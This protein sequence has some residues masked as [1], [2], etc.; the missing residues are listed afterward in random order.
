[1]SRARFTFWT[2]LTLGGFALVPAPTFG[3]GELPKKP[4]TSVISAHRDQPRGG[5]SKEDLPKAREHFTKFA[6]YYADTIAHPTVWKAS[7]EFKLEAPGTRIPTLDGP[8]GL[9]RDLDRYLIEFVPGVNRTNLEPADYIRELGAALDEALK[10]L[11]ETNPE[12]IVRVNAARMLAHVARTGAP[13]HFATITSLLANPNTRTEVKYYLF[14]A[15]GAVLSASDPYEPKLRKHAMDAKTVGALIKTLEDCINTPSLLYVGLPADI[16]PEDVTADQ[17]AVI[18]LVR[19][20]AIRALAQTKFVSFPGPDGKML[21]PAHTLARVALGDPAFAPAPGPVEA[22]EAAIGLCNM[23]PVA[24]QLKGGFALVKGYN[25]DVAVEAILTALVTFA[26]PRAANAYDRTLAWRTYALRI[27]DAM[28]TWRPL[29]D[30]E[31]DPT[32]PNKFD[33]TLVPQVVD[34][35]FKE[36]IPKV[37]APIDKVDNTGK[38]DIGTKVEIEWLRT[39]LAAMRS[40][41]NRKTELFSGV[42]QTS[43]EFDPAKK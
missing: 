21:Y 28:R 25:P 32:Q 15:A 8:E 22:A 16:K 5:I 24:E 38:P 3:Q 4:D 36:V 34:S 37:L 26:S 11:I 10:N 35:M 20:Q 7:Q 31:F 30:P 19:R 17:L 43:I 18:G 9:L 42:P 6:R 1:M 12:P 33:A 14:H 2:L 29:F 40:R 23:A 41:P 27:A 39:R 13:A